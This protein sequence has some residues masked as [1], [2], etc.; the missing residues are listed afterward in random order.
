MI[1]A[2]S[3]TARAV[4]GLR[5]WEAM[6]SPYGLILTVKIVALVALGALGASYRRRLIA[7]AGR[8]CRCPPVLD[9]SS[10]A[11]SR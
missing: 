4:I 9:V 3:G 5:S 1:V 8:G 11:S 2:V 7:P 6:L 10:R